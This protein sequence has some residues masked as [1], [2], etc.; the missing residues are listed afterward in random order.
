MPA[1]K[2]SRHSGSFAPFPNDVV[3]NKR[4]QNQI[5]LSRTF[6][7]LASFGYNVTEGGELF[8]KREKRCLVLD[9][10]E[11]RLVVCTYISNPPTTI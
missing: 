3:K 5:D 1:R 8:V 6:D 11:W 4:T 7:K 10:F 2:R 9:S